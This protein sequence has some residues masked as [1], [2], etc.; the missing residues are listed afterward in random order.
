M[1]R[2]FRTLV[3]SA[4]LC[5]A[6]NVLAAAES[7]PLGQSPT[8]A[9][10]PLEGSVM[11][12]P[13]SLSPEVAR[14]LREHVL[15]QC[16]LAE[17]AD[18]SLPWYF[19]FEYGHALLGAGDAGR[20]VRALSIAAER[21]PAPRAGKRM[22]GMWYVDYFPYFDLATAHAR[23]GNWPCA[24]DAIRLSEQY[25]EIGVDR[26]ERNRYLQLSSAIKQKRTDIENCKPG[27]AP[28][29]NVR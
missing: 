9:A 19:H 15:R 10:S 28:E 25:G 7:L 16:G 17:A 4:A 5:A 12:A 3:L 18:D 14:A 6:G 20:A 24:A 27:D 23:L 1:N 11:G 29:S 21:N 13:V 26:V 2:L 8:P 22:Y